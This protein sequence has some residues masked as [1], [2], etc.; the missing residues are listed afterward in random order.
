MTIYDDYDAWKLENIDL[1]NGLLKINSPIIARFKHVF[2]LCDYLYNES[3]KRTLDESSDTI[4]AFA[5]YYISGHIDTIST[6]LKKEYRGNIKGMNENAKTINLLLYTHDFENE[7]DNK[8][9]ASEEDKNKLGEFENKVR[10][11]IE[12][13]TEIPDEYFRIL[14][15]ITLSIFGDEY[16]DSN[17]ILYEA[18]LCLGLIGEDDTPIVDPVFGFT[19]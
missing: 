3:L 4:F 5:I 14:D 15:D 16:E 11:Y 1:I 10:S 7:L 17:E 8:E 2:V 12:S 19:R 6:I 9:D 18:A 13:H